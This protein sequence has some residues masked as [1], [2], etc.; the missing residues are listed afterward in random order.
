MTIDLN[1]ISGDDW[2]KVMDFIKN[3]DTF[4]AILTGFPGELKDIIE[5]VLFTLVGILTAGVLVETII[6]AIAGGVLIGKGIFDMGTSGNDLYEN[7]VKI[8][9]AFNN[10]GTEFTD[11]LNAQD[12]GIQIEP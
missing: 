9:D 7:A 11:L 6:G 10:A 5:G 2:Q 1:A 4:D 12:P 3:V 8:T